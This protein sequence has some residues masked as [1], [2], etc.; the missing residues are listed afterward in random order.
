LEFAIQM[1]VAEMAHLR[2]TRPAHAPPHNNVG[3]YMRG[4]EKTRWASKNG[5]PQGIAASGLQALRPLWA[6]LMRAAG[7]FQ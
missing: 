2:R 7:I 5:A 4:E 1:G 3:G 6:Q